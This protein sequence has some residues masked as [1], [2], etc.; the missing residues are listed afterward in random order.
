MNEK[1]S[2]AYKWDNDDDYYDNN[3]IDVAVLSSAKIRE[4]KSK[5]YK[6]LKVKKI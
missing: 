4:K 2:A 6:K 1:Q 5:I 3:H